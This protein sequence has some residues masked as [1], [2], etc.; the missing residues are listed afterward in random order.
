MESVKSKAYYC[1]DNGKLLEFD[2]IEAAP[3]AASFG[4]GPIDSEA[5][6]I[7]LPRKHLQTIKQDILHVYYRLTGY[8]NSIEAKIPRPSLYKLSFEAPPS[9]WPSLEEH[10]TIPRQ[11]VRRC[12][13]RLHTPW[14]GFVVPGY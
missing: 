9:R 3:M 5:V 2:V 10:P 12:F 11:I 1:A 7:P 8:R 14:Y 6:L 13:L 4:P